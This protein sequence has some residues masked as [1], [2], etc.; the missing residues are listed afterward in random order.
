MSLWSRIK[1]VFHS[2]RH[3]QEIR[4]ELEFHLAMDQANGR[5]AR[6][7]RLRLGNVARIAEET[8]S[9]GTVAW[10]ELALQDAKYGLRQLRKSPAVSL[11]IVLSLGIGL[12][13]N[14][15]IFTLADAALLKPLPVSDPDR[16]VMLEWSSEGRFAAVQ[17][18]G[19]FRM[20]EGGRMQIGTVSEAVYRELAARQSSF[21]SVIGFSRRTPMAVSDSSGI[22]EQVDV[23]YVSANFFSGLGVRP[24]LGR[25]FLEQ[26]DRRGQEPA[27][28]LSHRFWSSRLAGDSNV[29]GRSLR[30]NDVPVRIVGIA[31]AGFFGPTIGEWVDVYAPLSA[32]FVFDPVGS[33]R[34]PP[35]G[36]NADWWL[37]LAARLPPGISGSAAALEATALFRGA[38]AETTGTEL[39]PDL[40]LVAEPGRRGFQPIGGGANQA[41]EARALRILMLLVAVLLLIVCANVANLLLSRSVAQQRESAV[42][43]ALG[44][45]HRQLFRQALVGSGV[46]AVAGACVG[47]AL[48]Y[49]LAHAIHALFQTGQGAGNAY[50]LEPD[51]R[52][53]AY[54]SLL[55][56]VTTLL[57][58]LAPA[59]QA[60]RADVSHSLKVQARSVIGGR[61]RLPRLL[62]SLQLALCFA[63][64]VGAG[65]LGRSFENLLSVDLGFDG[66]NLAYATVNPYQAGYT[67]E[68]VAPYL[69]ALKRDLEAIPGVLDVAVVDNR[70]LADG[71][72]TWASTPDGPPPIEG[73]GPNPAAAVNLGI[74]SSELTAT[75]GVRLLAGRALDAADR[76]GAP[77]AVVDERFAAVFFAGRNPVGE[78]FTMLGESIEVVGLAANARFRDLREEK[79]PTVYLPFDPAR[80][81]PG[82]I[83]FAIRAATGADQLAANVRGVVAALNPAVP[84]TEFHTQA[85]LIDR[86]LRTE[87]LLAFLSGGFGLIALT[88]G[89]IGLGGLLA[90]AVA[91]RTN[92][93]GVRMALGA[94]RADV[95]R[96]ILRDATRMARLGILIGLP[97]AYGVARVLQASL[98][99]LEP[100]DPFSVAFALAALLLVALTAAWLP[101]RRAA[102]VSPVTALRE[103]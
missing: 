20:L 51:W 26:E 53:L 2:E 75:L 86:K 3:L 9:A 80:F 98:F 15:A 87:R 42:R 52:V 31:P 57:F 90:Y 27:V 100:V 71:R 7:A 24:M 32:R 78:H 16:L 94:A 70:P 46:F 8:H 102:R 92:E 65:L 95:I 13:A 103:E 85:G 74:G 58:G 84:M 54:T 6:E 76:P 93:I 41:D 83:H 82:Q 68:Q 45:S 73:A 19:G 25:P 21:D 67:Q 40:Q 48:G 33:A 97:A 11:A 49:G 60:A 50:A 18:M 81:L 43:L 23:Q 1:N 91:R 14:T 36:E 62:V 44:A 34:A 66:E 47:L 101:A 96:M 30:I 4:E 38:A 5:D 69:D 35:G 28:V 37:R 79:T 89:A 56:V 29:L 17:R 77:V 72:G 12:G 88:L 55:A 59:I 64:L 10:L 63:A 22:A 99:E 61:L 39:R